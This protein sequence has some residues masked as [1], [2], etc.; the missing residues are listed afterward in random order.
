MGKG[1]ACVWLSFPGT[2]CPALDVDNIYLVWFIYVYDTDSAFIRLP[3]MF[4][5]TNCLFEKRIRQVF[6]GLLYIKFT[7]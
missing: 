1:M 7:F 6:M 5:S 2:A 3:R 4:L